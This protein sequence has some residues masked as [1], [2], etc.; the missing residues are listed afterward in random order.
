M[1]S[2]LSVLWW[3]ERRW[4][5]GD[6]E[7]RCKA[8]RARLGRANDVSKSRKKDGSE[9]PSEAEKSGSLSV[10]QRIGSWVLQTNESWVTE[11]TF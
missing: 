6:E 7:S 1:V 2:V 3:E 8:K 9:C 10:L 5:Q 11:K 4:K